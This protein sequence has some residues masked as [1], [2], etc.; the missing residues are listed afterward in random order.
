M[1]SCGICI[2]TIHIQGQNKH[3]P[4]KYNILKLR[5]W[6]VYRTCSIPGD[7]R[8]ADSILSGISNTHAIGIHHHSIHLHD[9]MLIHT[10]M[11][12]VKNQ[13]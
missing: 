5:L 1:G 11:D 2:F 3:E 12:S 6:N 10:C 13:I 4:A 8:T 9:N 7:I